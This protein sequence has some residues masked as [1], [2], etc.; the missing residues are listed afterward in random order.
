[1]NNHQKYF[2]SQIMILVVVL[3][4]TVFSLAISSQMSFLLN[5][6]Q[7]RLIMDSVKAFY[8]ADSGVEWKMYQ[9]F[10]E[11]NASTP[12]LTNGTSCCGSENVT[13]IEPSRVGTK[14]QIKSTGVSPAT[15]D[16]KIKRTINANLF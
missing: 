12:S 16:Q 13:I 1:M 11:K 9:F 7:S 14:F 5:L 8:A 2:K 4:T 6:R 15:G 10:I 3:M